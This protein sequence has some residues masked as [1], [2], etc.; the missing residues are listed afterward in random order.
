MKY[1]AISMLV[2]MSMPLYAAGYGVVDITKVAQNS[3]YLKQQ[4]ETLSQSMQKERAQLE[5]LDKELFSLQQKLQSKI[6]DA[7]KQKLF[8][9][10]QEAGKKFDQQQQALQQKMQGGLQNINQVF[11]GRLKTVAEQLRQENKLDLVLNKNAVFAYDAK[12]DL[13]DKMLQKVNA[14]K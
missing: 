13:T 10:Y 14:M 8:T 11:E 2:S 5:Q 4:H 6:S 12:Y 1:M 9:Q 3:V 7:E